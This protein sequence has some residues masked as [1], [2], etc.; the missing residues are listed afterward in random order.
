[1]F[2]ATLILSAFSPGFL[3]DFEGGGDIEKKVAAGIPSL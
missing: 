2:V 1:V 3:L